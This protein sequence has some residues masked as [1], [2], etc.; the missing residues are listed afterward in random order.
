MNRDQHS[1]VALLIAAAICL[2]VCPCSSVWVRG[3]SPQA[4]K[5]SCVNCHSGL[6]GPLSQP[7]RYFATDAHRQAGLGCTGCHGGDPSDDSMD[8]MNPAKGFRG[9]PAK[10]A[11]PEF[12]ARCHANIELIR[13]YN[14]KLRV[15]QFS[16][17][18]TSVHGKRLKQGDLKVAVCYDCHRAHGILPASDPRSS[19]Y[20][21]T[22]PDTCGRCHSDTGY[23]KEYKIPTDQVARYRKSVHA[24]T[25]NKG[26]LA[27][28]TCSD[29]IACGTS[30]I[31]AARSYRS[32]FRESSR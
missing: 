13:R 30:R 2:G 8:A 21:P 16:E 32:V 18:Q 29:A 19:V 23:M 5:D 7:A 11:V 1:R 14:P 22:L 4:A 17:Y 15:D 9:K 3:Q 24:A 20:P 10:R 12:C 6:E 31:H 27:A 26:D 28:P 25:L